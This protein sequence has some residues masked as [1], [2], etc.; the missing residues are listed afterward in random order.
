MTVV[1]TIVLGCLLSAQLYLLQSNFS[2]QSKDSSIIHK[3]VLNEYDAKFV[4]PMSQPLMRDVGTQVTSAALGEMQE[5]DEENEESVDTYTPT[6][7]INRGFRTRPNPNY[8]KHVDPS[9]SAN[10]RPTP[11]R[12]GSS[13]TNFATSFQTPAHLRDMSSPLRPQTAIRQPQFRSSSAGD[14]G[15]LGVF[16]HANS[17]LKKSASMRL[18]QAD[19]A[20]SPVKRDGSPLKRSSLVPLPNGQRYAHYKDLQPRRD[21]GGY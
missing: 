16:S 15:S 18:G 12:T 21:S 4:H 1:K 19:R 20:A 3:E 8:V 14:G 17:P 10:P 5:D 13:T 9:G 11:S 2:Q 6:F 7:I